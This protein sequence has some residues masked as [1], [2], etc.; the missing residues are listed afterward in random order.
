MNGEDLWKVEQCLAK[1]WIGDA[2]ELRSSG[3]MLDENRSSKKESSTRTKRGLHGGSIILDVLECFLPLLV[4]EL[5][6]KSC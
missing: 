6:V 3:E 5:V 4:L 1:G 2:N